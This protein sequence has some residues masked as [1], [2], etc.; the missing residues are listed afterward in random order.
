MFTQARRPPGY[1]LQPQDLP[2]Q[3]PRIT[4]GQGLQASGPARAW[5]AWTCC[6]HPATQ[7]RAAG[8]CSGWWPR[9][10][11]GNLLGALQPL[12][13]SARP[14]LDM[15]VGQ[16]HHRPLGP[17]SLAV[18]SRQG[19]AGCRGGRQRSRMSCRHVPV[20]KA[21]PLPRAAL[22]PP[23]LDQ[24]TQA[25]PILPQHSPDLPC[26]SWGA[27]PPGC[28]APPP[29]RPGLPGAC[30]LLPTNPCVAGGLCP[31]KERLVSECP[32]SKF[33]CPSPPA[34]HRPGWAQQAPARGS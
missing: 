25:T 23:A 31:G 13:C 34:T 32:L 3:G 27:L 5:Q 1:P 16:G 18:G 24:K 22:L 20:G 21:G 26:H 17:P 4:L 28:P 33:P 30:C 12:L 2:R 15:L 29:H 19:W 11:L 10:P 8:R 7:G 6:V 14:C 9:G